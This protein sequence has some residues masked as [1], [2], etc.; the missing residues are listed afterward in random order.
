M[1]ADVSVDIFL[2]LFPLDGLSACGLEESMLANQMQQVAKDFHLTLQPDPEPN[3]NIFIRSDQ[4]SFVRQG[5]PSL[6]FGFGYTPEVTA[7][8]ARESLAA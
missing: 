4:Y 6:L 5:V 3:R 2:P 1:V 8:E 7:E